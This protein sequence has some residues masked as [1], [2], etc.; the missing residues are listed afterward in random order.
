MLAITIENKGS[1]MGH[2]KKNYK[3]NYLKKLL[4]LLK[5]II[6]FLEPTF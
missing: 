6:S 2:T 5:N 3:K 4:K 1:Q